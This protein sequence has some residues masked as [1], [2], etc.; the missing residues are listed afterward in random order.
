MIKFYTVL[1]D[2]DHLGGARQATK[3]S[4]ALQ[5][6]G[7]PFET[8]DLD[9]RKVV[10]P[11]DSWYRE[12]N[13]NGRV[14]AIDDN[15]FVLWECAAILEYLVESRESARSLLPGD[16]KQ[17]ATIRKWM[18]WE[19]STL[20]P[21]LITICALATTQDPE[22]L[23]SPDLEAMVLA[24]GGAS[25]L[26]IGGNKDKPAWEQAARMWNWD[27]HVL[28]QGLGER[29]F[30]RDLL[31][32]RHCTGR[33]RANRIPVWNV[34][35]ALSKTFSLDSAIGATEEL[36]ANVLIHESYRS[37]YREEFTVMSFEVTNE[38]ASL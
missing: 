15:G 12:I 16:L 20:T 1:P 32:R 2:N 26:L 27:L 8:I 25:Y 5:E 36:S 28:E 29:I 4:I 37:R 18:I 17:R 30:R 19:S 14:P 22:A 23:A 38:T 6:I 33:R 11:K 24:A 3:V 7:E 9:R 34:G 35:E 21:D 13:P 10:R 31:H